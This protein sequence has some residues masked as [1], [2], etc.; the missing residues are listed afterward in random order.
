[1]RNQDLVWE[2][3]GFVKKK[4]GLYLTQKGPTKCQKCIKIPKLLLNQQTLSRGQKISKAAPHITGV[5]NCTFM[6][7][8]SD[9]SVNSDFDSEV[10]QMVFVEGT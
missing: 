5:N 9:K 4:N 8:E 6:S 10:L 7:D 2:L 3:F 1:M